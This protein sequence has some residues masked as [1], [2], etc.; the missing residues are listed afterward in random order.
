MHVSLTEEEQI[1]A[2]LVEF[3][4]AIALIKTYKKVA[5]GPSMI[6][7]SNVADQRDSYLLGMHQSCMTLLIPKLC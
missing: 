3:H 2:F 5:Q 1:K 7:L 6:C 4:Y